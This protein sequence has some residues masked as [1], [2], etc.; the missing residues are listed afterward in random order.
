MFSLITLLV[1]VSKDESQCSSNFLVTIWYFFT[2]TE[3]K[4][5]IKLKYFYF[6]LYLIL[7]FYYY[8]LTLNVVFYKRNKK[9]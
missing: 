7:Y 9:I 4:R 3:S 8:L 2:E 1:F 5:V 6:L